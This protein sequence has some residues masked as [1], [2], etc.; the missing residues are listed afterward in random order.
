MVRALLTKIEVWNL[1]DDTVIKHDIIGNQFSFEDDE[2][3]YHES[4]SSPTQLSHD[5]R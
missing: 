5:R 1:Q 4:G 3:P 2:G